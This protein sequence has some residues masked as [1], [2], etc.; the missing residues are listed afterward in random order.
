M[1][2]EKRIKKLND[3]GVKNITSNVEFQLVP[4]QTDADGKYLSPI[5]FVADLMYKEEGKSYCEKLIDGFSEAERR[6]AEIASKLMLRQW[7]FT[8]RLVEG[9]EDG[10]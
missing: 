10:M 4:T 1:R 9:D 3:R 7:G 8:V 2:M 5:R 6:E